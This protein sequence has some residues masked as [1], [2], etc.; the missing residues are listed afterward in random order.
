MNQIEET[1]KDAFVD[2]IIWSMCC[3]VNKHN[4]YAKGALDSLT[5]RE[6][7]IAFIYLNSNLPSSHLIGWLDKED[8]IV[9][10]TWDLDDMDIGYDSQDLE[11]GYNS[12]IA[13]VK[14]IFAGTK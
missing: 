5:T 7:R 11:D 2:A 13:E 1:I 3:T 12:A 10:A 9:D 8:V 14:A 4:R 6:K